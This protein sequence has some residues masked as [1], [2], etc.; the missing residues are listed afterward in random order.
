MSPE[1]AAA[2]RAEVVSL[3]RQN[4][5][6]RDALKTIERRLRVG[7]APLVPFLNAHAGPA[8]KAAWTSIYSSALR[9]QLALHPPDQI[10]SD[11]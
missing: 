1:E 4:A 11:Q 8:E 7:A 3:R 6:M 10:E 5:V 2:L 9:A